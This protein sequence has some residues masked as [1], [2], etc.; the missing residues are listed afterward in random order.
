M[1][2]RDV[3]FAQREE[4]LGQ[5]EEAVRLREQA[6]QGQAA[7]LAASQVQQQELREANA[8]L[9]LAKL[10]ADAL[11]EAA[12]TAGRRQDEFLAMLAH[13]LRT[14]LAPISSAAA[15]LAQADGNPEMLRRIHDI[16]ARQVHHLV[17]LVDQL[18]DVSR[19]TQ[20]RIELHKRPVAVAG[21]VEQAVQMHQALIDAQRQQLRV[22]VPVQPLVVDGDP[23]RLVQVVGNLLHNAAKYTPQGGAIAVTA[24]QEG[25]AV[26]ID[27]QDS[28]MGIAAEALPHIF[29]LFTQGDH[30]LARS[31][32]GLGIGLTLVR[33]LAELHGGSV[34]AASEGPG[35]GSA[36]TLRLP[37]TAPPSAA[38]TLQQDG[39][40]ASGRPARRI[41]IVEDND[42]A[43]EMLRALLEEA[44]HRLSTRPDG[45]SGLAAALAERPEV[46]LVDLGL[47]GLSGHAL[48]EQLRAQPEGRDVLLVALTGYGQPEDRAR[49]AAAGFDLHAVKPVDV[50]ALL[51]R[52]EA[53]LSQR[54]SRTSP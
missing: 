12:V 18:L 37:A 6:E 23:V 22:H 25:D 20:G 49:S 21:I 26:L 35:R 5:R 11:K 2:Q 42:D 4:A 27:V 43:R 16:V 28:G 36:F 40:A 51:G 52:I 48:A 19:V 54:E 3:A 38:R 8:H 47:P 13:E 41:L 10:E 46:A 45:P 15:L 1:D 53:A 7:A 24:R 30:S 31:Q 44:G 33:R 50:Q 39:A 34:D 14:P 17:R 29:E 32:G 9:V